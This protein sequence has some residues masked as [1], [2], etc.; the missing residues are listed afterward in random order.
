MNVDSKKKKQTSH[1]MKRHFI[2][3]PLVLV[4]RCEVTLLVMRLLV[5][6]NRQ[7][8]GS[9]CGGVC[10]ELILR[11]Q[12]LDVLLTFLPTTMVKW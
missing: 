8:L 6:S 12:N 11:H 1:D 2:S 4:K 7:F 9:F 5:T 10:F 3:P